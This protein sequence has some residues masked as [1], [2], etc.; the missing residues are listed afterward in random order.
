V[1]AET[2]TGETPEAERDAILR[3]FKA[4]KIRAVTNANIL[5]T[6]FDYP[7]IDLIVMLRP[8]CS[9]GLYMQMVGR[10]LRIK[11][12]GGDCLVLDFAGNVSMHGPIIAV[13]PPEKV[14]KGEGIAPSKI[15]P[16]CEE[17]VAMQ[18][19]VC[20]CCGYAFTNDKEKTWKLHDD[21]ISGQD[22]VKEMEVSSWFW[23]TQVSKSG[24][25]MIVCR[26]YGQL[27]EKPIPEYF[28]VFHDGF[29]GNK[30]RKLF[31]EVS[32][33]AGLKTQPERTEELENAR[34]P[35]KIRY[36]K[37]GKFFRVIDRVWSSESFDDA[38]PF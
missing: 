7:D 1:S 16:E 5:T 10:G 38:I 11:G 21:D 19:K 25:E 3:D 28:C 31:M 36:I 14:G 9:A 2:V 34:P 32:L 26:Y 8:T 29:A 33:K 24:K 18:A 20:P 13:R 6:G 12:N 35:D 22:M 4:G 37:D 17:M 27:D 15:C 23:S 30:A